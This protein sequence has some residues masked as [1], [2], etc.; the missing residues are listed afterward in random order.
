[1]NVR[2]YSHVTRDRA[3]FLRARV[4]HV[5]ISLQV[6]IWFQN[7]RMKWKRSKKAQQE[8]RTSGKVEDAGSARSA[9]RDAG[10]DVSVNAPG[11]P[12]E[13]RATHQ[14]NQRTGTDLQEPLYRPYVV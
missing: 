11:T 4:T 2:F 13:P 9:D 12:E 5:A 7:R 10:S 3:I 8:A 6:K 1:M 14:E